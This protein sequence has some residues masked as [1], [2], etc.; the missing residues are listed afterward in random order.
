PTSWRELS[1][2]ALDEVL[3]IA[4]ARYAWT[5]VDVAASMA[6][7]PGGPEPT[8]APLR[9]QA[10][11]AALAAADELVIVGAAEPIGMHRRVLLL[12]ELGDLLGEHASLPRHIV[13][14]RL[15]GQ[16]TGDRPEQ[17]VAEALARFAGTAP[18]V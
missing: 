16:A 11:S 18:A 4:R 14:N 15:R 6:E 7:P 13:V 10:T 1:P 17:A 2:A 3:T 8:F 9:G 12:T 5:V